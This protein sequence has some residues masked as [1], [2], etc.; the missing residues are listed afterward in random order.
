MII[1]KYCSFKDELEKNNTI[2]LNTNDGTIFCVGILQA[3]IELKYSSYK[4]Q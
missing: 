1:K 3:Y 4:I 2:S